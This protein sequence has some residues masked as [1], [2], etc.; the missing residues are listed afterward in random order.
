MRFPA[1]MIALVAATLAAGCATVTTGTDD[2]VTVETDPKGASCALSTE[3]GQ[4][5]VINPTPGSIKTPKSRMDLRVRCEKEGYLPT[6]GV[7]ASNFAPMTLG[8][9]LI[10]GVIGIAV[11]AASG[12]MTD[13]DDGVK[14]AL[15]PETFPS[16]EKR[17]EFF[18][19]LTGDVE[20]RHAKEV[21]QI[22]S[23]CGADKTR[24]ERK[25]KVAD[26]AQ[27]KQLAT[28]EDQRA[29][30]RIEEG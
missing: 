25:L 13:Y 9:A 12:A 8:N 23:S 21:E 27:A 5:A 3:K 18:D 30:A 20:T 6:E 16:E 14:I 22:R 10:G 4:V 29:Q 28:L 24:C 11:D 7:I 1:A 2:L 26:D 15:I 19:K 17:D